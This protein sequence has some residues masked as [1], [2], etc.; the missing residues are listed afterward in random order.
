MKSWLTMLAAQSII[1]LLL[2]PKRNDDL[3]CF[4]IRSV[5]KEGRRSKN[6]KSQVSTCNYKQSADEDKQISKYLTHK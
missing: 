6:Y 1:L 3:Q 5:L 4:V 2:P